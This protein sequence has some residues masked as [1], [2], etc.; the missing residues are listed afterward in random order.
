MSFK[1]KLRKY[2]FI[3]LILSVTVYLVAFRPAS[4][5]IHFKN[6]VAVLEYH[7]INPNESAYSIS[8]E[9]FQQHLQALKSNHYNVISMDEFIEFLNGSKTVPPNAVVITFD[10]GYESFYKYAYPILKKE[11]MTA[12]E[13]LIV[14]YVGAS[15]SGLA[16]LNWEEAKEMKQYGFSFYSHTYHSHDSVLGA[17][18]RLVVL[19]ER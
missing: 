18:N 7:D 11:N 13:F 16:F 5:K 4:G 8:P 12:T 14:S 15:N 9:H 17:D 2:S 1:Y 6:Q 3:L 19:R 10:D